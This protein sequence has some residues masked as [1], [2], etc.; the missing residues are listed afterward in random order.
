MARPCSELTGL[1]R[2]KIT[3]GQ[4]REWKEKKIN[5]IEVVSFSN[6]SKVEHS[7]S[8]WTLVQVLDWEHGTKVRSIEIL[9]FRREFERPRTDSIENWLASEISRLLKFRELENSKLRTSLEVQSYENSKAW[10]YENLK[11]RNY[12]NLKPRNYENLKPRNYENLKPRNY[13]NLKPR[14][15]EN[16]KPWNYENSKARNYENSKLRKLEI[17]KTWN[18]EITKIWN[19]EDSNTRR[20]LGQNKVLY[21]FLLCIF[22]IY[23]LYIFYTYFFFSSQKKTEIEQNETKEKTI[24]ENSRR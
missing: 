4:I 21:I 14:N 23:V 18:L 1:Y 16:S 19:L 13:E 8:T 24:L 11:P 10:N 7:S 5:G 15:Y 3:Y 6:T 2:V 9:R 12:E 22:I 20:F 17:T